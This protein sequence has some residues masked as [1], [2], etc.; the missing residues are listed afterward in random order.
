[1]FNQKNEDELIVKYLELLN[2]QYARTL[3]V[4]KTLTL[5]VAKVKII[6]FTNKQETQEVC[7]YVR[8]FLHNT[9]QFCYNKSR[10]ENIGVCMG[11]FTT[12]ENQLNNP[13]SYAN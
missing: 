3:K 2:V 1:M 8:I 10:G 4:F 6:L 5:T 7:R 9:V 12:V 13:G 11:I